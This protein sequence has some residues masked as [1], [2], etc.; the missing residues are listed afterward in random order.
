MSLPFL[1]DE[2]PFL[3]KDRSHTKSPTHSFA[4]RSNINPDS[5]LKINHFPSVTA[6]L[7]SLRMGNCLPAPSPGAQREGGRGAPCP[8]SLSPVPSRLQGV[9]DHPRCIYLSMEGA[10][11]WDKH[12]C[13]SPAGAGGGRWGGRSSSLF[14]FPLPDVVWFQ[15]ALNNMW[16]HGLTVSGFA[17]Q[18]HSPK[19]TPLPLVPLG[20]GR[21][22]IMQGAD[23]HIFLL[24]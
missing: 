19:Q 7:F 24:H 17:Q 3:H 4:S 22:R 23:K 18:P 14:S 1:G 2:L 12:C 9:C 6:L 20:T 15:R 11:T 21:R 10:W 5:H 13:H 8:G 16:W